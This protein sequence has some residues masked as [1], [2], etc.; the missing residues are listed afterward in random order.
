MGIIANT[1]DESDKRFAAY[2][3]GLVSVLGHADRARPLRDYCTGLVM[4]GARKSV[5]PMAAVTAPG[6]VCAQHQS[7]LHFVGAPPG[8]TRSLWPRCAS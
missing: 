7:L 3:A 6:R 2:V 8:R 1:L 4:P 5:E